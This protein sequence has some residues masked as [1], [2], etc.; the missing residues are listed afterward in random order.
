MWY[1]DPLTY[2]LE[3]VKSPS[4]L[5]IWNDNEDSSLSHHRL[6]DD[7]QVACKHYS[8]LE[9]KVGGAYGC[10]QDESFTVSDSLCFF[11]SSRSWPGTRQST[12][13]PSVHPADRKEMLRTVIIQVIKANI[14]HAVQSGELSAWDTFEHTDAISTLN[15]AA[16]FAFKCQYCA[17]WK[18]FIIM[19]LTGLRPNLCIL[20][21]L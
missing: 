6:D 20:E 18:A 12:P 5:W 1:S 8:S 19:L 2:W 13:Q 17:L 21:L 16:E 7:S 14:K 3:K 4:L 15:T 10:E 9:D 11:P